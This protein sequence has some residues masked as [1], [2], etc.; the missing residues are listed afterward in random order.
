MKFVVLTYGTDGDTRPMIALC[1]ALM[2]A[3]HSPHLLADRG[4]LDGAHALGVP[5]S[6]I[7]GDIRGMLDPAAGIS[8]VV[9][10]GASFT[11]TARALAQIANTHAEAWMRAAVELGQGCDGLIL[12]GLA[13]FVGLSAAQALGI[14]AVG[15]SIIPLTPTAEF[16][17]P[18]LP[19]RW[20]PRAL[21]R[22]SHRAANQL[23]WRA[24]RTAINRAR[25]AVCGLPPL[26]ALPQGHPM[27]YGVSPTLL[28]QPRD[29]PDNARVCGQWPLPAPAWSPSA[30]LAEFL[31][32]GD[33]PV[34]IGFGSMVG[35]DRRRMR[36]V[37]VDAVAGRRAVFHPGWSGIDT[38]GL[39][40]NILVVG[41]TPH[42]WLFPRMSAVVHHGGA[43]T[44]HTATRAGV[45]SV[46][47]PFAGDQ[48]FWAERLRH[49]GVAPPPL[50]ARKMTARDLS[51][52]IELAERP[53]VRSRASE[54]GQAMR[55]ED[56][57][58][59]GVE[60]IEGLMAAVG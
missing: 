18:F 31:A 52:A 9:E 10:E 56:G 14:P 24:F 32:A 49:L 46:V 30:P 34:Y 48:P 57:L 38:T 29:W 40:P 1:R 35:F 42:A 11:R 2:Q 43:G 22:A 44:A 45:P 23:F 36:N 4:T 54:L 21:H 6:A 26:G 39:P 59:V 12:S 19:P 20:V 51:H 27:L 41:E 16:A 15:T 58:A 47:V 55:A 33:A 3:G 17:S 50:D 25:A 8:G 53:A 37:I 28:P 7:A 13:G 5:C 60:A